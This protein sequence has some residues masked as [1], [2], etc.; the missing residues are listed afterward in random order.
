MN[1]NTDRITLQDKQLH[2]VGWSMTFLHRCLRNFEL[3]GIA[4][5]A[6]LPFEAFTPVGVAKVVF[7]ALGSILFSLG[8]FI[9]LWSRGFAKDK[10]FVLD[11]PYRY[12][13]NP[14]EIGSLALYAGFFFVLGVLWSWVLAFVL[15][16]LAYFALVAFAYELRLKAKVGAV[17]ERYSE[18]VGRWIPSRYPGVNRSGAPFSWRRSLREDFLL[19]IWVLAILTIFFVKNE[20]FLLH[21]AG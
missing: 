15:L 12:V 17:Y 14:D 6:I 18:R 19:L 8:V 1:S 21:A 4:F 16:N 11:G 2:P 10:R 5:F 7:A 20:Q 3:P 9:R 13:R